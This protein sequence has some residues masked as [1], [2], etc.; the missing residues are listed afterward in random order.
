MTVLESSFMRNSIP[1]FEMLNH[2]KQFECAFTQLTVFQEEEP[3]SF[4]SRNT[5]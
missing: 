4:T 2:G 3:W 1:A 5:V